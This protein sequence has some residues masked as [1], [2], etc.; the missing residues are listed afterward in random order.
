[1]DLTSWIGMVRMNERSEIDAADLHEI[2]LN[3]MKTVPHGSAEHANLDYL[4][5]HFK[6]VSERANN[7][8]FASD[9][10][11]AASGDA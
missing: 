3:L 7:T 10:G 2:L 1:M 11:L 6:Q 8:H 9:C 4:Q 5:Q